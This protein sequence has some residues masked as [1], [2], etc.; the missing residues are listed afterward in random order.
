MVKREGVIYVN[1]FGGKPFL[2]VGK[3]GH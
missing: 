3:L 1:G 2:V